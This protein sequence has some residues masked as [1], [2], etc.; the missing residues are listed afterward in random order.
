VAPVVVPVF[1][2]GTP[3]DG[4]ELRNDIILALNDE[5]YLEV[6]NVNPLNPSYL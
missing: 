5:L 4:V 1:Q 3:A 2:Y 6:P